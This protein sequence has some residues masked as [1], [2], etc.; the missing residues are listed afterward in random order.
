MLGM[1]GVSKP[2]V[3]VIVRTRNRPTFLRRALQ[4][5]LGQTWNE[6]DVFVVNDGGNS[7]L[8]DEVVS[9]RT[10]DKGRIHVINNER[11][12]GRAEAVNIGFAAG[13][14][15]F[16]AIHDDDDSWNPHFLA[17]MIFNF[18]LAVQRISSVGGIASLLRRQFEVITQSGIIPIETVDVTNERRSIGLLHLQRYSEFREDVFPIQLLLSREAMAA[19]GRF[20]SAFAVAEDREFIARFLL[21]YDI[22]IHQR[23][24]AFHHV[25]IDSDETDNTNS[26]KNEEQMITF[27]HVWENARERAKI[28]AF[29]NLNDANV[30]R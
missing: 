9:E 11:T 15:D 30:E 20:N 1:K 6:L 27:L 28:A 12:A 18:E 14:G 21:K 3:D 19:T 2:L 16:V 25:R 4:S 8:V 23:P 13:S 17:A 22:A 29:K 7:A 5:I 10:A 24:L 26:T